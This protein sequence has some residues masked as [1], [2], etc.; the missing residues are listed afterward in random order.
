MERP[1]HTH[2]LAS[3]SEKNRELIHQLVTLAGAEH[4]WSEDFANEELLEYMRKAWIGRDHGRGSDKAQYTDDQNRAMLERMD[5][6]GVTREVRPEP[7]SEYDLTVVMGATMPAIMRRYKYLEEIRA[8]GVVLG[9]EVYLLGERPKSAPEGTNEELLAPDGRYAG[10]DVSD[11]PWVTNRFAPDTEQGGVHP[12]VETD[13]G[14]LA[15]LKLNPNLVVSQLY[16]PVVSI[17]GQD[18]G[19][20]EPNSDMPPRLYT[21]ARLTDAEGQDVEIINGKAVNRDK[22]D[23]KMPYRPTTRST[24]SELL[25]FR[26][27]NNGARVLIVTSSPS[28]LRQMATCESEFAHNGRSDLQVELAAAPP[29]P[30]MD[31]SLLVTNGL[32]EVARMIEQDNRK[33]AA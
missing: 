20:Y 10:A 8:S 31:V 25:K 19:E 15:L 28:G 24:I 6:M 11:I 27:L 13:L 23:K 18:T 5:L 26:Q 32:G 14:R 2:E 33:R 3:F 21:A 12:I 30:T 9:R 17:Y 16:L 29:P 22:G 4:V 7:G 1:K